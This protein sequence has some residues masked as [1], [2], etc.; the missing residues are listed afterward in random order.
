[1]LVVTKFGGSSLSCASQFKKVKDI[2]TSNENRKVVVVSALGKRESS[3]TKITDLLYII[4]AHLKYSVAIDDVWNLLYSRFV[5]VKNDLK[6]NYDIESDLEELKNSLTKNTSDA[7]LVSRGEYLT[8]KLMSSY[9]GF[10][11][12]DAKDLIVFNYDGTI[13]YEFTEAKV[14]DNFNA[15]GIV[16]PGFYGAYPNGEIKLLSR[17]GSDVTGSILAKSLNANIY[18]NWTDVS[19]IMMADPRLVNNPK[20]VKELTY[21]ELRELS[22]MGANVLHEETIFPIQAL[23]IP[24]NIKNTNSPNDEGTYI[25]SKCTDTSSIITGIAGKKDFLAISIYK[26]HMSNEVGF[27]KKVLTVLEKYNIS[28]EHV[29]TGIDNVS[30]VVSKEQ[31]ERNLHK[32]CEDIKNSSNADMVEV[33]EPM[34]LIA[35]VGRNMVGKKGLSG[36]I[37]EI[38]GRNDINIK[39]IAQGPEEINIIVGVENIAYEST[40]KT[41]YNELQKINEK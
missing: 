17:G 39:M 10:E 16:V 8:A 3:D 18:E 24:I 15:S 32:I 26:K 13:N 12:V 38:F 23:D 20:V 31:L 9:L 6:I 11:F 2:I 33:S 37:F 4:H 22:Y 28:I 19:G 29:P 5:E 1:M 30:V 21:E 35:I 7:Y 14:N 36:R 41:L 40:I 25:R 27:L 34:A